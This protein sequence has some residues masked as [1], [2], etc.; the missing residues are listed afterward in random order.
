MQKPVEYNPSNTSPAD[1]TET[2]S[3]VP[4]F[5]NG[6]GNDDVPWSQSSILPSGIPS[7]TPSENPTVVPSSFPSDAPNDTPSA[8]PTADKGLSGIVAESSANKILLVSIVQMLPTM[9]VLAIGPLR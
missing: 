6:E 3:T 9:L 7:N 8:Q 2:P 5:D 1:T 4:A